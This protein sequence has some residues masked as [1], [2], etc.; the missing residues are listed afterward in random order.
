[1]KTRHRLTSTDK[2]ALFFPLAS[3]DIFLHWCLCYTVE[4][5]QQLFLT[6]PRLSPCL[7]Q[8]SLHPRYYAAG[9]NGLCWT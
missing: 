1:V 3:A 6:L 7:D 8:G 5:L 9:C 4:W 2:K